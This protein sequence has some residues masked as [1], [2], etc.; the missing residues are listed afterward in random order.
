MALKK[1]GHD[2][3]K[4]ILETS[5]GETHLKNDVA[6]FDGCTAYIILYKFVKLG[7]QPLY[8]R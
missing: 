3:K 7:Y 5:V 2:G 4:K 1:I 8:K 6:Y